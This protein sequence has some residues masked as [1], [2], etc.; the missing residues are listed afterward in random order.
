MKKIRKAVIPAAGYGTRFLPETKAMPKEM[1]PVVDKPVIQYVV[2]DLVEAGIEQIIIITGW[3]KRAI[4]DHFDRHLELENKLK[5]AGKIEQLDQIRKISDMAEF[6]YVRQKEMRGNGDAILTAK[7]IVGDEP[8]VVCWGDEIMQGTPNKTTQLIDAYNKYGGVI[9]GS[10]K[11]T[12][13]E[14]RKK[15]GFA[16]GPEVEPGVVRIEELIEKPGEKGADMNLATLG[17]FVFSPEIFQALES[18]EVAEGDE[19]VYIDGIN[20]LR[21]QGIDAYAVEIKGGKYYDCGNVTQYLKTNIELA[22]KR[23]GIGDEM[24]EFIQQIT[25]S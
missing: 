25:K 16:R 22:L 11:T 24:R 20:V 9:M 3:H 8:F 1:L 18:C 23:P 17:G 5:T 13:P 14:D 7:N 6:V 10:I 2:E 12:K 15:Y 21:K 4:E 19:L